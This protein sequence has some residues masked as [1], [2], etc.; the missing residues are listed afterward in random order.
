MS[1][2]TTDLFREKQEM[3]VYLMKSKRGSVDDAYLPIA[4]QFYNLEVCPKNEVVK[5]GIILLCLYSQIGLY[6]GLIASHIKQNTK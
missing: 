5:R 2:N 1:Q 6:S 4:I 3:R